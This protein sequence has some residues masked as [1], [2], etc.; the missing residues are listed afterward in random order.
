VIS[1]RP[2]RNEG[3]RQHL[4][5]TCFTCGGRRKQASRRPPRFRHQGGWSRVLC[6]VTHALISGLGLN[7]PRRAPCAS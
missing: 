4:R 7:W 6:E 1:W 3:V 5:P 2:Q